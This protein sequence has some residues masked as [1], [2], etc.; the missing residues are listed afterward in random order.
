MTPVAQINHVDSGLPRWLINT[1]FICCLVSAVVSNYVPW[2]HWSSEHLP[3]VIALMQITDIVLF[4]AIMRGMRSLPHSLGWLWWMLI[5]I[6]FAGF[7][8]TAL[9]GVFPVLEEVRVI[10]AA[11]LL[12]AYLPLGVS[13]LLWYRGRLA[14]T[15][16]WMIIYILVLVILPVVFA[17]TGILGNSTVSLAL[18]IFCMIVNIVFL[19]TLRRV[20]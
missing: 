4:V 8:C 5:A 20:L 13:L 14:Q 9:Q 6:D 12:L 7:V 2:E 1:A 3:F 10:T 16:L 15:G 18:D 19:I 17:L 11:M